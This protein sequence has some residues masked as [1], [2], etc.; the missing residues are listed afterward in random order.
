MDRL[1]VA[2]GTTHD[3][4]AVERHG[5]AGV[6]AGEVAETG[7][8]AYRIIL[9]YHDIHELGAADAGRVLGDRIEHRLDIAR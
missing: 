3:G 2:D 5:L 9:D 8:P 6:Q 4:S 1:S 7:S